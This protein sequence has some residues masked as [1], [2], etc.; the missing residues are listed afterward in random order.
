MEIIVNRVSHH[1]KLVNKMMALIVYNVPAL[2]TISI[3]AR[4]IIVS[5]AFL[6]AKHV[7]KMMDN[8]L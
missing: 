1:V 3:L 6:H 8:Y 2:H 7:L 4:I 5:H